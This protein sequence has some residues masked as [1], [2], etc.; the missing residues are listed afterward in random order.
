VQTSL[1]V[2]KDAAPVSYQLIG[3]ERVA[4]ESRY[5]LKGDRG[6]YG[7]AVGAY[8]PRYPLVID[9]GLDYSTFLGGTGNDAGEDIAV[10][11]GMAYVTGSTESANFPTTPGAFDTTSNDNW[12]AFV[13]KLPAPPPPEPCTITGTK[14]I[15]SLQGTRRSDVIC[16]LGG[17]DAIAGRGGDDILRGGD[18]DDGI[19]GGSGADKLFGQ[20]GADGLDAT[21][22]V[23]SNDAMNGG[24]GID[25][26]RGDQEDTVTGCEASQLGG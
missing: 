3:G 13:T 24:G 11:E 16:G 12:D 15:D 26:C 7:F 9:P 25:G 17:N 20:E 5:T 10:R 8:D 23:K 14:G 4:V 18:G 19:Q 6:G 21:D 22:G 2:L 1:G